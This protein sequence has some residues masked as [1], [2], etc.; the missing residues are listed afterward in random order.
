MNGTRWARL[1]DKTE[2]GD[3]GVPFE[4]NT[5]A[6]AITYIPKI[7]NTTLAMFLQ[8][9][10]SLKSPEK[11][12]NRQNVSLAVQPLRHGIVTIAQFHP[13]SLV[14][15]E[16]TASI[17]HHD[18]G[19]LD[20]ISPRQAPDR[21]IDALAGPKPCSIRDGRNRSANLDSLSTTGKS[22]GY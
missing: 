19:Q 8:W 22:R 7:R 6:T 10:T 21:Y 15:I 4:R 20:M 5:V 17:R 11:S 1:A 18:T 9:Q 3:A 14:P 2:H 12:P 16:T 13:P